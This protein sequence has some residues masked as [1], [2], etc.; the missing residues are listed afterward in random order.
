MSGNVFVQAISTI[1]T[2]ASRGAP[3]AAA[4]NQQPDAFALADYHLEQLLAGECYHHVVI[5]EDDGFRPRSSMRAFTSHTR[6]R[7]PGVSIQFLNSDKAVVV[8]Y[9]HESWQ[10]A[11]NRSHQPVVKYELLPD[12]LLRVKFNNRDAGPWDEWW[13]HLHVFNIL[14]TESPSVDMFV[15]EPAKCISDLAELW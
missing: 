8:R 10:G 5:H 15:A 9:K 4:R 7:W 1:W 14:R 2:K 13:Y 3:Q 12:K 6:W 11:P